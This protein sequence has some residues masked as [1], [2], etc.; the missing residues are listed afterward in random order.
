[1]AWLSVSLP[2]PV[3]CRIRCMRGDTH[4]MPC[5]AFLAT[6]P[7]F[8]RKSFFH[9]CLCVACVWERNCPI[10]EARVGL[11]DRPDLYGRR[12]V[13]LPFVALVDANSRHLCPVPLTSPRM[14]HARPRSD[15]TRSG[16]VAEGI[17]GSDYAG[18]MIHDGWSH[19]DRFETARHQQCLQHSKRTPCAARR[20][21]Y[22]RSTK[23]SSPRI[24]APSYSH[25]FRVRVHGPRVAAVQ[26]LQPQ[27]AVCRSAAR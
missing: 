2:G 21:H 4:P 1:L 18:T 11:T 6:N 20:K 12:S 16:A 17:L 10:R 5:I 19:Y 23:K 9:G 27:M 7:S 25:S 22:F 3:P 26:M 13:C 14:V 15:P 8:P 24:T